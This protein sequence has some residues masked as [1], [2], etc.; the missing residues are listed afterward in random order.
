MILANNW[1]IVTYVWLVPAQKQLLERNREGVT[2]FFLAINII[3]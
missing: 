1:L 3:L 2:L